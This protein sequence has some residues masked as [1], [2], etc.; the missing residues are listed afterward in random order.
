MAESWLMHKTRF[1]IALGGVTTLGS[2]RHYYLRATLV[3]MLVTC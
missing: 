1:C 3:L 2:T